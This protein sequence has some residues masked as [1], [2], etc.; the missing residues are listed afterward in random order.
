[1]KSQ[2]DHSHVALEA[3]VRAL[4]LSTWIVVAATT[5]ACC[6]PLALVSMLANERD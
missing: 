4:M 1:M 6:L 3:S 5:L 2:A